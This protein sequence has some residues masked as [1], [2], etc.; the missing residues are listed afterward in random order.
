[1]PK[2]TPKSDGLR[3]SASKRDVPP[4]DDAAILEAVARVLADVA[5]GPAALERTLEIVADSLGLVAGWVWLIDPDTARFYLAASYRLPPYLQQP[6]QMTGE[7]CWCI[8]S[9][10]DGDF[11]SK[12]VDVIEC[13]RLRRAIAHG[14]RELTGELKYHASVALRFGARELGIM[15]VSGPNWRALSERDLRL[16]SAVGAQTG[17]AVELARLSEMGATLARTQ[18]RARLARELHDTLAQDLT[19]IALQLESALGRIDPGASEARAPMETAL[20]VTRDALEHARDSVLTLRADPLGGRPLAAALAGLV[21]RFTSESGVIASLHDGL[22]RTL[23]HL[24]EVELFRIASEALTNVRNHARAHRAEVR[25]VRDG[26]SGEIVLRVEDD[27]IGYV[28]ARAEASRYGIVGMTERARSLG[29]TLHVGRVA[30]GGGTFVE[31]RVPA[32]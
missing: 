7:T 31:A 12:N 15:N 27:G 11:V 10:H 13:S 20:A 32:R 21:R 29:G 14:E 6:V 25:L 3:A 26:A 24:T 23:P 8:E 5:D 4:R 22:S 30:S 16:L 19:A 17:M 9:F 1:M 18:E 2:S 28:P